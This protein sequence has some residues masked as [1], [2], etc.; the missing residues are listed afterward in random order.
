VHLGKASEFNFEDFSPCFTLFSG[1]LSLYIISN[2][3][4]WYVIFVVTVDNREFEDYM[5]KHTHYLFNQ[6]W[7]TPG[8]YV[9]VIT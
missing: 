9:H 4:R 3:V 6:K 1:N 5:S 8:E 7:H 2:E